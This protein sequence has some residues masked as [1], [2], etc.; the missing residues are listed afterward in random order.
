[1][2]QNFLGGVLTQKQERDSRQLL[3]QGQI[4]F[5]SSK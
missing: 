5:G 2:V 3:T 1:M 4:G